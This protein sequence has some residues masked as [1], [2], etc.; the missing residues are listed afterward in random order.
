ML[1]PGT[2]SA[3]VHG[4]WRKQKLYAE[5]TLRETATLLGLDHNQAQVGFRYP[6]QG[7]VELGDTQLIRLDFQYAVRPAHEVRAEG[8][9]RFEFNSSS[10]KN[11]ATV[12][13]ARQFGSCSVRNMGARRVGCRWSCPVTR[14][15][16]GCCRSALSS[17]WSR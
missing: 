11:V 1:A 4:V 10:A 16:G 5:D 6:Q 8:P 14:S 3:A 12:G 13:S 17:S 7:D 15:I 2:T 9:P